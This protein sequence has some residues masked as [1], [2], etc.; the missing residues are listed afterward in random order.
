VS[1]TK[2]SRNLSIPAVGLVDHILLKTTVTT[3]KRF[4]P[5]SR[6]KRNSHLLATFMLCFFMLSEAEPTGRPMTSPGFASPRKTDN[7]PLKRP[8]SSDPGGVADGFATDEEV[9]QIPPGN[10]REKKQVALLQT[11]AKSTTV[12]LGCE[13]R[14]TFLFQTLWPVLD[15]LLQVFFSPQF[16][17][18]LLRTWFQTRAALASSL[19][20]DERDKTSRRR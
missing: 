16:A 11:V 20:A 7:A 1:F 14:K 13:R 3:G 17:P 12:S 19:S 5:A 10:G 18:L 4:F 9:E 8:K 15:L 6:N 2:T